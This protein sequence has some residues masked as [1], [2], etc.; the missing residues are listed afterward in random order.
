MLNTKN[1]L[2]SILKELLEAKWEAYFKYK[3]SNDWHD[4]ILNFSIY[5]SYSHSSCLI[6]DCITNLERN[7]L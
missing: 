4:K 7:N 3:F 6:K 1:E 2:M 5:A